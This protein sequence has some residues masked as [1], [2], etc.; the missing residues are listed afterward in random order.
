MEGRFVAAVRGY[1]STRCPTAMTDVAGKRWHDRAGNLGAFPLIF[2]MGSL[3]TS[4]AD[5][6]TIFVSGNSPCL[7]PTVRAFRGASLADWHEEGGPAHALMV[8][9]PPA[10]A[11]SAAP[12]FSA[13][14]GQVRYVQVSPR[15]GVVPCTHH[16][17]DPDPVPHWAQ[18]RLWC[19]LRGTGPQ[20]GRPLE[21]RPT[22]C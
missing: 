19:T 17:G 4:K 16:L 20:T 8:A 10:F 6:E 18:R 21:R 9:R 11:A 13:A 2:R 3:T 12:T 15:R 1:C 7:A 5:A 14:P 22:R